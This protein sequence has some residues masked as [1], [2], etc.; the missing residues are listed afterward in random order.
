MKH[1]Y[2]LILLFSLL[3]CSNDYKKYRD[4]G[5][6]RIYELQCDGKFYMTIEDCSCEKLPQNYFIPQGNKNDNFY[7]F[8]VKTENG[9]LKIYAL[10]DEFETFGHIKSKI[11]FI[12]SQN[13]ADFIE[14][15]TA[16][17]VKVFRG[18]SNG[19]INP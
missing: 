16:N 18:Y 10:Y 11:D 14:L 2:N 12:V 5:V 1:F 3:S 4:I 8:Y 7:E 15:I 19:Q 9:R 13:N 17:D 6:F